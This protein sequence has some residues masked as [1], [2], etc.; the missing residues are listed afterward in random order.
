[1]K[2]NIYIVTNKDIG[3]IANND[4]KI[5]NVGKENKNIKNNFLSDSIGESIAEKNQYYCELTALYWIWKN[6]ID[7]SN[8]LVGLCHYRRFFYLHKAPF[9][10][11]TKMIKNLTDIYEQI[12]TESLANIFSQYDIVLPVPHTEICTVQEQYYTDHYKNDFDTV[13]K[14]LIELY[15]EYEDALTVVCSRKY[16]YCYNMFITNRVIFDNYMQWLFHV[17]F[18]TEKIIQ[19][20]KNDV[21][22]RRVFGF[23]AERLLNVY[24]Y[25]NKFKVKEMPIIY[26]SE[27]EKKDKYKNF[28]YYL[29]KY[30]FINLKKVRGI[31]KK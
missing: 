12:Q 23:L 4:Y 3:H 6:T 7:D 26:I 19:V 30:S 27:K 13:K 25:H 31:L 10:L 24:V 2:I 14:V 29:K 15:P 1:M 22:Q 11:E 9:F 8:D 21:Y 16:M 5:I 20:N 28:K 18:A 17:L